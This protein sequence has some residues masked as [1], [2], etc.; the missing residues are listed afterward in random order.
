MQ[1]KHL[2]KFNRLDEENIQQTL[3]RREQPPNNRSNVQ[4]TYSS[5]RTPWGVT[6]SLFSKVRDRASRPTPSTTIWSNQTQEKERE[7]T[8]YERCP[9]GHCCGC[10]GC[11]GEGRLEPF[12]QEQEGGGSE[13]GGM[14]PH[15]PSPPAACPAGVV[16]R[17]ESRCGV[18]RVPVPAPQ[19]VA[20]SLRHKGSKT[21]TAPIACSTQNIP[22][23]LH[24]SRSHM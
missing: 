6:K 20:L 7:E 13:V 21:S 18:D 1:K 12:P 23:H 4:K 2:T 16:T 15:F 19:R 8:S 10:R 3:Q 22:E 17:K 14:S 9:G 24:P 11:R 5:R